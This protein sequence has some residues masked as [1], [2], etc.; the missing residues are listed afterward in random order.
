ML[1][2]KRTRFIRGL[3][4][5]WLPCVFFVFR[6]A[7]WVPEGYPG[8]ETGATSPAL[9]AIPILPCEVAALFFLL[10]SFSRSHPLRALFS[11]LTALGSAIL[12]TLLITALFTAIAA[13]F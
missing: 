7:R 10:R 9:Y 2:R 11:G 5:A 8:I 6:S 1:D 3:L 13:A 12:I 4:L